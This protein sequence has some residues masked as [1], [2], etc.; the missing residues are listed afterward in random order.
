MRRREQE[1]GRTVITGVALALMTAMT[2]GADDVVWSAS[3]RLD[4][5]GNY[6][7]SADERFQLSFPFPPDFLPV[8]QTSGFMET[9]DAGSHV[10]ASLVSLTLDVGRGDHF[11][12]RAK[13]DGIDLYE[14]NPTS[15]DR[16]VDLDEAW[17]RFGEKPER[18]RLPSGTSI[19]VLAGKAPKMERQPVRLLESYGLASTAFNRLED[20]QVQVGGS[21]GRNF[22]WRGQYSSGNP[23]FFRDSN[24]LAGDNGIPEL[25]EKNPDPNLKSGF[26]ILYDAEVE[27]YFLDTDHPELGGALGWVWESD[28]LSWAFD[29][30]AFY[31]EREMADTVELRG[32]FYGG[33]LDLFDAAGI[34]LTL[35]GRDKEETGARLYAEWRKLSLFALYVD[36]TFAGLGR[37][38]WEVEAGWELSLRSGLMPWIRPALRYS[39]LANDF[40]GPSQFPAPSIWWD[41]AKLDVGARM[42]IHDWADLTVEYSRHDVKIPKDLN[43]DEFL[44][45]LRVHIHHVK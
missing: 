32:T 20:V 35:D 5:H 25:L 21:I 22:Y 11:A 16:T 9:V 24:A 38:G 37:R 10:E 34:G 41:W 14:R 40:R 33:D 26:P 31:Y 1:R 27:G 44:V 28:D 13:I 2:V 15:T 7:N 43:L 23:L 12:A 8:G 45:T 36:Q 4:L 18:L 29:L 3:W 19:F 39:E 30:M 42:A 17:I 6:R